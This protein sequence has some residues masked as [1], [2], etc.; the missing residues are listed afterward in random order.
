[1]TFFILILR[2]AMVSWMH[3]CSKYITRI[4]S[5][6]FTQ[7][8]KLQNFECHLFTWVLNKMAHNLLFV[9]YRESENYFLQTAIHFMLGLETG[10][11][12]NSVT[13]KLEFQKEKSSLLIPR[14]LIWEGFMNMTS[15]SASYAYLVAPKLIKCSYL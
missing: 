14:W 1:M 9:T 15:K 13:L 7:S 8:H 6:F 3:D 11:Q 2:W 5:I 12:M 10:I 4:L